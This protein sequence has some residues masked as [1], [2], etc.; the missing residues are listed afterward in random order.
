M[1]HNLADDV[2]ELH[3]NESLAHVI[4]IKRPV[5]KL[6]F[7]ITCFDINSVLTFNSL[8]EVLSL[9]FL[10]F[11]VETRSKHINK[12]FVACADQ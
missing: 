8:D 2:V 9:V 1:P 7:L 12:F 10:L 4:S 3:S 5:Y 6:F 11:V